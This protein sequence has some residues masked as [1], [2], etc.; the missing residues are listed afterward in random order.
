MSRYRVTDTV[1]WVESRLPDSDE[2]AVYATL[3]P[4][5]PPLVMAGPAR[6]IWLAV[7]EGGTADEVVAGTAAA[8]GA[9]AEDIADDVRR[10]LAELVRLGL[11]TDGNRADPTP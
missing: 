11:V 6:A 3:L 8:A 10:H 4:S 9:E 2:S 5:G 7:V 1:A